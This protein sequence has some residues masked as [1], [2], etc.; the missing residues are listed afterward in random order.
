MLSLVLREAQ[1]LSRA[2]ERLRQEVSRKE[3]QS[4]ARWEVLL[5][6]GAGKTVPQIARSLGLSR[7][8]VQ[9]IADLLAE[10]GALHFEANPHHKRS[11]VL[12]PTELGM[13]VR[14]RLEREFRGWES[15]VTDFL[16]A[17]ELE[18]ALLVLRA[19]RAALESRL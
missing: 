10:D 8:S 7:Q 12:R 19:L 11:P 4:R 3:K 17:E 9:R 15:S 2:Y 1:E 16:E 5:A 13:R 18:T 14:E 6:I